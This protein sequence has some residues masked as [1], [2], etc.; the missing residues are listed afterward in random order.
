M[1]SCFFFFLCILALASPQDAVASHKLMLS[2]TTSP[3]R[4]PS[5][6]TVA[7]SSGKV[8]TSYLTHRSHSTIGSP[9]RSQKR[10]PKLYNTEKQWERANNP[11][12]TN[13]QPENT[14]QADDRN[15]Q[16]ANITEFPSVLSYIYQNSK[17]VTTASIDDR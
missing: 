3:T 16:P 4:S 9:T 17:I 7:K 5:H 13:I 15:N 11:N 12:N 6:T 10:P 1:K 14:G 8:P 2:A